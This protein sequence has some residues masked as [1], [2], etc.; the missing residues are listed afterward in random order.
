MLIDNTFRN[1]SAL[2]NTNFEHLLMEY[3]MKYP[4]VYCSQY[5]QRYS[6]IYLHYSNAYNNVARIRKAL[7][8]SK[9]EN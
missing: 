3:L 9:E 2:F 4:F 8:L 5:I 6:K 7:C 1:D